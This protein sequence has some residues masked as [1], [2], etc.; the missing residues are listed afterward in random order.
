MQ[1]L[2]VQHL[3]VQ[4]LP[5]QYLP[6]QY[7]TVQYLTVQYLTVQYLTVQYLTMQYLTPS[8]RL[9]LACGSSPQSYL[10]THEAL[11]EPP[12]GGGAGGLEAAEIF[13]C[14]GGQDGGG[15]R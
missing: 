12:E 11:L 8:P 1:Y 5:V 6:V 4:Y 10:S 15:A 7:L 3:P 13:H 2:P 9:S 14:E